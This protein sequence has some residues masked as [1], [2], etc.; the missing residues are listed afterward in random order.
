MPDLP[1]QSS[2]R[3]DQEDGE[4]TDLTRRSLLAGAA[5]LGAAAALPAGAEAHTGAHLGH[6]RKHRPRRGSGGSSAHPGSS[7]DVIVVGGGLSGLVAARDVV[8]AG[9]SA[10]VLEA[11]ERVG[12]RIWA[13][14]LGSGNVAERGATFLGPTQDHVAALAGQLGVGTFPVYDQGSS[15]YYH[16]GQRSLYSDTSP[17]GTAPLDPTILADLA[18]VV[19][20]LDNKAA[21]VDVN[22]PWSNPNAASWD[23]MTLETYVASMSQSAR[24]R[25]LATVAARPIFGCEARDISLLFVVFY[26]ASSGNE[27]NVGT[28]ERNFNTRGGAQMSRFAG[29]SQLL[30]QKV[31]ALLGGRVL[32]GQVARTVTQ[33]T[34]GVQVTTD[35]A[36]F[37]GRR[38]IMAMAPALAGRVRYEPLMPEARDQLM[39]RMA[40]GNLVKATAVYDKPFWR[41]AGLNGQTVS[42]DGL[43]NVTFD[44][45]P[46]DGSKGV[47]LSFVG[48]DSARRYFSLSPADRRQAVLNDYANYF[49]PQALK[50]TTY[51]ESNWAAEEF[52]RGCPVGL[53]TPGTISEFGPAIRE[54][55]GLIHWAGTETSNY[56]NG[57]MDGAVRAGQRA[58]QEVLVGL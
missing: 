10:M 40:Q 50:P 21:T 16:D 23:A 43:A 11:R 13:Y 18:L 27:H 2:D 47:L 17:T 44:D 48:G 28:F 5:A 55:V 30:P 9:H 58:A 42:L 49:G 38:V 19:M 36:T 51:I 32:L 41:D 20:D 56:W 35:R 6:R 7:A 8:A 3:P 14:D 45:S 31:A 34:K 54:P 12:G 29:G 53:G 15:V 26:V 24:F 33:T 1:R 22:S 57:Y 4:G 25:K 52:T 37:S 46:E 39:Q